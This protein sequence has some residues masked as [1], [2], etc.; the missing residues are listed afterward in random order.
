M[1]ITR[2]GR[3]SIRRMRHARVGRGRVEASLVGRT[4]GHRRGHLVV[5]LQDDPLGAVFAVLLDV[6]ALDDGEGLHDVVH[7]V[8]GDAI[9]MEVG[10][11]EL[12]AQQEAARL[13][14]AERRAVVAAVAGKG[15]QVPG[16][17]GEFEDPL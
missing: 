17:V 5:D 2:S 3:L 1:L 15:L 16:G 13:V 14:P 7:V 4:A 6:L 11:V 8:A 9:E 10:G 12:A